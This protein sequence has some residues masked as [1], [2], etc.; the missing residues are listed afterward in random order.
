MPAYGK[1][2]KHHC[3]VVE[4]I[5]EQILLTD[6]AEFV[7]PYRPQISNFLCSDPW[8]RTQHINLFVDFC[9]KRWRK[10][11]LYVVEVPGCLRRVGHDL[12]TSLVGHDVSSIQLC[13]AID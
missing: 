10:L 8:I 6:N 13:Q 7:D 1:Q 5:S 2:S 12:L 4:A 9:P 3:V 11:L